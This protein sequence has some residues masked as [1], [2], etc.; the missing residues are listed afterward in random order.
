MITIIN[1]S[2]KI[3]LKEMVLYNKKARLHVIEQFRCTKE[4]VECPKDRKTY[5]GHREESGR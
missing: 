2:L 3:Y 4:E 5:I 1:K